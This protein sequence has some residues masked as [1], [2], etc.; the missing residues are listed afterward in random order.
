MMNSKLNKLYLCSIKLCIIVYCCLSFPI[1]LYGS[2]KTPSNY[3]KKTNSDAFL[4]VRS[5]LLAAET[6]DDSRIK[7]AVNSST[8][9]DVDIYSSW[10]QAL[11]S[12]Y[13][14]EEKGLKLLWEIKNADYVFPE[15]LYL[16]HDSK[17][18][19]LIHEIVNSPRLDEKI[20]FIKIYLNGGL[21]SEMV[22]GDLI[23]ITKFKEKRGG[24]VE[25]PFVNFLKN[26]NLKGGANSFFKPLDRNSAKKNYPSI[27]RNVNI[28]HNNI[29]IKSDCFIYIE[30]VLDDKYVLDVENKTLH[31]VDGPNDFM[32]YEI[33]DDSVDPLSDP[34]DST[35]N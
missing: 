30:T 6:R 3:I 20:P 19:V 17:Y 28:D 26:L 15:R 25:F 23:N 7:N 29:I 16:S 2:F 1:D 32:N 12:C 4:V 10:G 21:V 9:T 27:F 14:I 31:R 13:R 11:L 22:L 35:G 8:D 33:T 24:M 5:P 34:F 18:L